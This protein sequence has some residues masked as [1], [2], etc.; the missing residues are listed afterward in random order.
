MAAAFQAVERAEMPGATSAIS[1]VQRVGGSIGIALLAVV[2]QRALPPT[3]AASAAGSTRRRLLAQRD[4]GH[5]APAIAEAF[6]TTFWVAF[7]LTA[8]RDPWVVGFPAI[9][10]AAYARRSRGRR[11]LA[12][13]C[14]G[15]QALSWP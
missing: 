12:S 7:A 14:S 10:R 15:G 8:P 1:G 11:G 2:F 4:P 3:S 5:A 13:K 6:G 9:E